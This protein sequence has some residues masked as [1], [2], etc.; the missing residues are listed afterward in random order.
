MSKF[1]WN[2][3]LD[4]DAFIPHLRKKTL[5]VDGFMSLCSLPEL[6]YAI[7]L[8]RRSAETCEH[9]API[10]EASGDTDQ[11]KLDRELAKSYRA[12][13]QHLRAVQG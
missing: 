10:H 8:L 3:P 9:N 13:E 11:A 12:A 4:P 6:E 5:T 2:Q 7:D 1:D